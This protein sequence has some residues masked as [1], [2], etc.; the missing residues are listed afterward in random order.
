MT[1]ASAGRLSLVVRQTTYAC[2]TLHGG[3]T[4]SLFAG[5]CLLIVI[6][7]KC[8]AAFPGF[9][10]PSLEVDLLLPARA[11]LR[12]ENGPRWS[13]VVLN[14]LRLSLWC[15]CRGSKGLGE[16]VLRQSARS[17]AFIQKITDE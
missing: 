1:Q 17:E 10:S 15:R 13:V 12:S 8:R 6:T 14:G 11:L 16:S 5:E 4:V 2:G 7:G 3:A 9:Q